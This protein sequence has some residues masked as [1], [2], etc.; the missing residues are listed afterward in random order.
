MKGGASE[1][2]N[3]VAD[4]I[5]MVFG[6]PAASVTRGT[7]AGDITGWDSVSHMLLMLALEERF[8]VLFPA[9]KMYGGNNAGELAD[10][11][12]E[13]KDMRH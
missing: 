1:I 2:F 5:Q 9:D 3:A 4:T 10:I 8:G 13:L 6:V 7:T 11:L 12:Q